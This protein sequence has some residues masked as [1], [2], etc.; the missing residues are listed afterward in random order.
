MEAHSPSQAC[1]VLSKWPQQH[2]GACQVTVLSGGV[3]EGVGTLAGLLSI[4]PVMGVSPGAAHDPPRASCH[5]QAPTMSGRVTG[6]R[7]WLDPQGRE[8]KRGLAYV[9]PTNAKQPP[10]SG[11]RLGISLRC[12]VPEPP[13]S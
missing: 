4:S 5:E 9:R 1:S 8:L 11:H 12:P 2:S 10:V 6:R 7:C 13:Y 3:Q